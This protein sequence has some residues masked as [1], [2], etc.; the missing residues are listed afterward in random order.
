M[1]TAEA[2]A[3]GHVDKVADQISDAI[4]DDCIR[5]DPDSRCAIECMIGHGII[6]ITG[7]L[8]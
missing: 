8:T 4:V 3:P 1:R 6:T 2:V 7:E 5:Q